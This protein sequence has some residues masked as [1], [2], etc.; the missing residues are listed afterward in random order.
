MFV[1][2]ESDWWDVSS[3]KQVRSFLESFPLQRENWNFL[4]LMLMFVF[5]TTTA[6]HIAL[7]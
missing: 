6:H 3:Q 1:L 5:N 2:K 7:G 4:E